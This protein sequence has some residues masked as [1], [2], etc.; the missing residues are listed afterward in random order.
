[1]A[2]KTPVIVAKSVEVPK[3]APPKPEAEARIT[4]QDRAVERPVPAITITKKPAPA[5]S[6][7]TQAQPA[8]KPA[9]QVIEAQPPAP[10]PVVV[11]AGAPAVSQ[12]S[13]VAPAQD[14]A[15]SSIS[16]E[17]QV[18]DSSRADR[19]SLEYR[20]AVA[21]M[22]E[23]RTELAIDAYAGVL[24]LDARHAAARQALVALLMARGRMNDARGV[25][26]DG[27]KV[28]PDNVAWAILLARLQVEG[29][30]AAGATETLDAGMPYGKNRADYQ[31]F[32]GTV[33]QMRGYHK[34]AIAHYEI[35]VR[36]SPQSGRALTGLAISL[37]EEKR[38]PE[39]RE[40][41]QRALASGTLGEDLRAFV[42]R[43]LAQLK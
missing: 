17:R 34:E 32:A 28:L 24:R 10:A 9:A 25:L 22:N 43:K 26:A 6:T 39:A 42:E 21:L 3:S 14:A 35:A 19:V 18:S 16:V 38:V 27:L 4:K 15:K 33:M 37:E 29:G 31:A 20:N 41:Y 5:T 36:L 8:R 23:G 7:V 13:A 11:A 1:M 30:D 40:A 2:A 12:S